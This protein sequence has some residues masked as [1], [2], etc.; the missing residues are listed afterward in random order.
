[1]QRRT[2]VFLGIAAAILFDVI[3]FWA[4]PASSSGGLFQ[5]DRARLIVNNMGLYAGFVLLI[6]TALI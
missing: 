6:T 5:F 4:V 1:M 3:F 2:V